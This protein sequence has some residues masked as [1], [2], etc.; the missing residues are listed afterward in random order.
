[1][2][3]TE[4]QRTKRVLRSCIRENEA[5]RRT[6]TDQ[7]DEIR[8]LKKDLDVCES[9]AGSQSVQLQA[10]GEGKRVIV[11][12]EYPFRLPDGSTE[13]RPI[14]GP[15]EVYDPDHVAQIAEV[16]HRAGV[17]QAVDEIAP[18]VDAIKAMDE[19]IYAIQ[20][21]IMC[22]NGPR[23]RAVVQQ[24][25]NQ[26]VSAA[27]E[28]N[29]T[30]LKAKQNKVVSFN[31]SVFEG[32]NQ[33]LMQLRQI[34]EDYLVKGSDVA[35]VK[36]VD[37][38]AQYNNTAKAVRDE[39]AETV[40]RGRA[41]NKGLQLIGEMAAE[42]PDPQRGE[43]WKIGAEIY[44]KL[45]DFGTNLSPQKDARELLQEYFPVMYP[46]TTND[47]IDKTRL[48]ALISR[49]RKEEITNLT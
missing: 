32:F 24:Y 40:R 13:I 15:I 49:E 38:I 17:Q 26:F 47:H 25:L 3:E 19:Q 12:T 10:L 16:A 14:T 11:T 42:F 7:Q 1:M 2:A 28:V 35:Q 5:Y 37:F 9:V 45:L 8:R 41:R 4:L 31:W 30:R 18:M 27:Q 23:T 29:T 43:Y 20:A 46:N 44:K 34:V 6:F 36:A 33:Y 21:A 48:G 39:F 22:N